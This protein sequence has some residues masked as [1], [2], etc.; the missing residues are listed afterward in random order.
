[1]NH[2]VTMG[3]SIYDESRLDTKRGF[4]GGY[5]LQAVQVGIPF[6]TTVIKPDGW[7]R[8]FTKFIEHYDHLSGIW[9]NGEDMP[10]AENRVTLHATEKDSF[11][12]PIPHVHVDDHPNDIAMRR[13]FYERAEAVLRAAGA[14]DIMRGTP[15]PASHNMGTCRMSASPDAGVTNSYGRTHEVPNLYVTDGSL[16]PTSTSENP[17]QTIVALAIRQAAYIIEQSG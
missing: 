6:L 2:G 3:G 12:V 11:G 7:G 17:T 1:M 15:L 8:E 16:F 4:V 5:L 10:C 9:M 14:V 13:H